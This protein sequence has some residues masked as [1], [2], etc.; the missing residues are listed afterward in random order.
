M[1]KQR[2]FY[3]DALRGFAILLVII[4][5]LPHFCYYDGWQSAISH[6]F[7]LSIVSC[8]H[9]PL[10]MMI[11]GYVINYEKINIIKKLKILIP[12]FFFGMMYAFCAKLHV[13]LFLLDS[14]KYGYWFLWV[15]VCFFSFLYIIR[16]IKI[17]LFAGFILFEVLF[18]GLEYVLPKVASDVISLHEFVTLWPFFSLGLLW[19][20]YNPHLVNI[21]MDVSICIPLSAF[22]VVLCYI[23]CFGNIADNKI[24]FVIHFLIAISGSISLF[25]VFYLLNVWLSGKCFLTK[26]VLKRMGNEI[27]TNTLQIYVLHYFILYYLDLHFLGSI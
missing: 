13:E 16:K 12:F 15:I 24:L 11:S 19:K 1:G 5:H 23:V 2:L 20:K 9:M 22:F 21:K 6:S 18:L 25:L 3:V 26:S 8:F 10:F 27:G 4:G 7:L 17:C 14:M